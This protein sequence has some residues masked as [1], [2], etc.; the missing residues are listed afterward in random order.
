MSEQ[1][2]SPEIKEVPIPEVWIV[3][4]DEDMVGALLRSW[5]GRFS[6]KYD[7]RHFITAK[8]A[9]VE[10]DRLNKEK[11]IL[12]KII[13]VDGQL[14]KDE[15]ELAYGENLVKAIR[16]LKDIQ[17]P[18]LIAHSSSRELNQA[19][20]EAGANLAFR[21]SLDLP[22]SKQFLENPEEYQEEPVG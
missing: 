18:Q 14:E 5:R 8:E 12:P 9:L 19:M 21:K 1:K 7:F 15:G 11:A 22:K 13:F 20:R 3:D 2:F 16:G 6:G 4:D 10:I 17:Q